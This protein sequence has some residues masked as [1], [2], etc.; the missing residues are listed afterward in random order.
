VLGEKLGAKKIVKFGHVIGFNDG[1]RAVAMTITR[2]GV[3]SEP[4]SGLLLAGL[5]L[6][7]CAGGV[8]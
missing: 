1:G 7:E 6:P 4:R 2:P 5:N 3:L 8:R